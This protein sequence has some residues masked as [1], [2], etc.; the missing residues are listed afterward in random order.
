MDEIV[1]GQCGN[2]G[3]DVVMPRSFHSVRMPSPRCTHCGATPKMTR[4]RIIPMN[5]PARP[6]KSRV[7]I[8]PD[9]IKERDRDSLIYES[10]TSVERWFLGGDK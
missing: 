5:P 3:H 2:C 8:I 6:I 7:P 10:N 1:L 4:S 9:H